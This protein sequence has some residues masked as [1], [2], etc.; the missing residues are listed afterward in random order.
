MESLAQLHAASYGF[1]E[2]VGLEH[3]KERYPLFTRANLWCE[4]NWKSLKGP[5]VRAGIDGA[6]KIL[7]V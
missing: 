6:A 5:F 4:A 2:E 3:C 7:E 1:I